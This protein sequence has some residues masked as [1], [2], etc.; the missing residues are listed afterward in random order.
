[1]LVHWCYSDGVLGG[2]GSPNRVLL[3]NATPLEWDSQFVS[4]E[5]AGEPLGK[6][7]NDVDAGVRSSAMP[8]LL[9]VV[10]ARD[11]LRGGSGPEYL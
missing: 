5:E 11:C 3:L 7:A 4:W 2:D 9:D 8:S 1:V 10:Y 6:G